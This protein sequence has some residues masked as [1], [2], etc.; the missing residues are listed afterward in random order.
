[1]LIQKFI[2]GGEKYYAMDAKLQCTCIIDLL[3]WQIGDLAG[4]S[5][6]DDEPRLVSV[7]VLLIYM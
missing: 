3:F 7:S 4:V 6:V 2:D 5:P 1:M